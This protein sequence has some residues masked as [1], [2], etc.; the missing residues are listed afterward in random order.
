MTMIAGIQNTY[1]ALSREDDK[2]KTMNLKKHAAIIL[3]IF[4]VIFLMA[5]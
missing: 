2:M 3:A 4:A 5:S 1:K